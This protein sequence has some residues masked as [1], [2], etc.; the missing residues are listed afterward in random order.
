MKSPLLLALLTLS[1][2]ANACFVVREL[3][4]A[5]AK[6]PAAHS[7]AS[8]SSHAAS[9]SAAT[10]AQLSSAPITLWQRLAQGD[11]AALA[12]LRAAGW[13]EQTLQRLAAALIDAR[14][15]TQNSALENPSRDYWQ[16]HHRNAAAFDAFAQNRSAQNHEKAALLQSLFGD[17]YISPE[18]QAPA[19]QGIPREKAAAILAI[20]AD[21]ASLRRDL[22]ETPNYSNSSYEEL[23]AALTREERADI[24]R[25]LTPGEFFEYELRSSVTASELRYNTAAFE[26]TEAEFRA[27][28]RIKNPLDEPAFDLDAAAARKLRKDT[29]AALD[30]EAR[31]ILG[32]ARFQQFVLSRDAEYRRFYHLSQHLQLPTETARTAYALKANIDHRSRALDA[33]PAT[34]PAARLALAQE[35]ESRLTTAFGSKGMEI[36]KL[37]SRYL[38]LLRVPPSE[39]PRTR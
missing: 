24:A 9:R 8:T 23:S 36:Y 10:S 21:Y 20:K 17:A 2:A 38:E 12:T 39:R 4:A 32:E 25:A 30:L 1:L 29:E 19:F 13:P 33:D 18:A 16:E 26:P 15:H 3:R 7:A 5:L 28:F 35:A 31:R 22:N 27:L 11:P 37:N 6:S 14:F 34:T